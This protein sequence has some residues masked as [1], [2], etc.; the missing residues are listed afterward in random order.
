MIGRALVVLI[1][2]SALSA[3]V[4][5]G[6][7]V[8]AA[9]Q[10][11]L[12]DAT[13]SVVGE[14]SPA[15]S[16]EAGKFTM[17]LRHAGTIVLTVQRL[18]YARNTWSFAMTASD[19]ADAVLPIQPNPKTLDTV[20]V[21][22]KAPV[23]LH[24]ADFER[25]RQQKNG[26]TFITREEIEKNPPTQ[27]AE[28][29]RRVPS[30]DVRQKGMQTVVVSRRGPV[31]ILLTQDMC[32]IPL[33]RDG[34]ILGPN[35]NIN[36]IPTN[37]IYGIEVYGGPATIPVEYRNSLPNGVCGLVMVWTRSGSTEKKPE[38]P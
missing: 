8:D 24:V 17:V 32:V 22:A 12:A 37:E 21:D 31:S 28:L 16:D 11:P 34:L 3:Q 20:S 30:V 14:P 19:T 26:G 2:P 5:R 15:R 7:I 1:I 27:T 25:R 36:D 10:Q 23:S 9:T 18:G 29:L 6:K 33:G 13:I 4:V 38:K 35:Y